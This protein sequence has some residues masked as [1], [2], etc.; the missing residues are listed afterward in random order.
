M[1]IDRTAVPPVDLSRLKEN[2]MGDDAFVLEMIKMFIF[3][4]QTQLTELRGLWVDGP[5]HDWVEVSHSLKGTSAMIGA[6]AMRELC[7]QSQMMET[8]TGAERRAIWEKI[9]AAHTEA[10]EFLSQ[11]GYTL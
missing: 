4:G 1:T 9:A 5:S 2:S 6:D 7:A 11:S 8:A 10:C 3:Q